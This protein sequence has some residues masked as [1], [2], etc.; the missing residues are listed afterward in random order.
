MCYISVL[1]VNVRK[2]FLQAL[3]NWI[4]LCWM[5]KLVFAIRTKSLANKK[6]FMVVFD[7]FVVGWSHMIFNRPIPLLMSL[8]GIRQHQIWTLKILTLTEEENL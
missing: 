6:S 8:K 3:E 5:L 1:L 2:K 4:T 7:T